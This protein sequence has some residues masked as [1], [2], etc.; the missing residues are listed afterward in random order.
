MPTHPR[1]ARV[2]DDAATTAT[3]PGAPP[4]TPDGRYLVV[5]GV[6]WRRTDPR[7]PDAERERQV[8][9]LMDARRDIGRAMRARDTAS[10]R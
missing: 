6:L 5:D 4:I 10:Q 8:S 7:L 2:R 3:R 9:A 1:S